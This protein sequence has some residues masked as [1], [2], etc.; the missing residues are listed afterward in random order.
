MTAGNASWSSSIRGQW[1]GCSTTWQRHGTWSGWSWRSSPGDG[2]TWCGQRQGDFTGGTGSSSSRTSPTRKTRM[3]TRNGPAQMPATEVL[4]VDSSKA[5]GI[6]ASQIS[7][8]LEPTNWG[9]GFPVGAWRIAQIWLR[10]IIQRRKWWETFEEKKESFVVLFISCDLRGKGGGWV[11]KVCLCWVLNLR[12]TLLDTS[13][14]YSS[15]DSSRSNKN[16][17]CSIGLRRDLTKFW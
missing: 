12:N 5:R 3:T 8:S 14:N 17:L 2:A 4:V 9:W 15:R 13:C 6:V 11:L 16:R 10:G 1:S 7:S